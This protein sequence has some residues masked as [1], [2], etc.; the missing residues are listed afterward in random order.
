MSWSYLTNGSGAVSEEDMPFNNNVDL[1]DISQIQ[2]KK[3]ISQVYDTES[4]SE[5]NS[6][7][8]EEMNKIKQHIQNFGSV[9]ACLHGNSSDTY[10]N[11]CYNNKTG[12]KYCND[13]S[14]HKID[15]AVSIIGWDDNYSIEN[16][17]KDSRPN[18][19]GAWI[20]K[21][22]W[23]EKVEVDLYKLKE[24]LFYNQKDEF[25]KAGINS[26]EEISN[27]MIEKQGYTID[28]D[29]AYIK[30][31]DNGI[32]YVSYEDVNIST[33]ITGIS[34]AKDEIE[35]DYIYQYDELFPLN[36]IKVN[37]TNKF[38]LC[39]K[40]N[41]KTEG[42]EYLTQVGIEAFNRYTCKVYVNPNGTELSKEKLQVVQLKEGESETF[43][44]GYH[45]LEFA[46]P[47]KING[48]SYAVVIEVET[49][50]NE[51]YVLLESKI[52][53]TFWDNTTVE[54]GKCFFAQENDLNKCK[55]LD[56]GKISELYPQI[57]NGDS[58][59]KAF[60]VKQFF[61]E[62]LENIE[63]I[64]PPNKV[65]YIE[66]ENFDK[67]G[68]VVRANYNSKTKP[69][70]VLDNS[71][72]SILDGTNLRAGQETIKIIYED[73][74]TNQKI[75]VE[76]NSVIKLK[77]VTP[78]N[79]VNYAE[80]ENFDKT[81]L[82]VEATYKNG[83]TKIISDYEIKDGSNLMKDQTFVTISIDGQLVKQPITVKENKLMNIRIAKEPNKKNYI[84]GQNFDKTGMVVLGIFYDE[85]TKEIT[86]YIIENGEKLVKNQ[87]F[88]KIKYQ[89]KEAIQQIEVKEKSISRISI[90][91]KPLKLTYEQN[92]E[93]LDLSGGSIIVKYN[94]NSEEEILLTSEQIHATGF[95]NKKT[96]KQII[97]IKYQEEITTFEIEIAGKPEKQIPKNSDFSETICKINN[98]KYYI[99]SD[100]NTKE[101]AIM[102]ITLNNI[103]R[104]KENDKVEYYYYLSSNK[105]EKDIN[106]WSRITEEQLLT[107]S[108]EFKVNTKDIQNF[109]EIYASSNLYIYVKEVAIKGGNQTV[110]I[111][112]AMEM[113][114]TDS[115][116]LYLDNNKITDDN[117]DNQDKTV[118]R[119]P[120][121]QTG[122][123]NILISV[124]IITAVGSV[125]FIKYKKISRYIK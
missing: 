21:N 120:I 78:P 84:V 89:D 62:S 85:T 70:V 88:V 119:K 42:T 36:L 114:P 64:T 4:F 39:N 56:L 97:T 99:F 92:K 81:G 20:V 52:E 12:A 53:G 116:E 48:S 93:E 122:L 90:K 31:G 105:K 59:I 63:V 69:Y 82:N 22:S 103:K 109:E 13:S 111:S 28:G 108:M 34:K 60:T 49:D 72:Y 7:N 76:K 18:E 98:I 41:K 110:I 124:I 94:D 51:G 32:I 25:I 104:N 30:Y 83:T 44:T 112:D 46:K 1:I 10:G 79:K 29:K 68:M 115:I 35:Y 47:I 106:G 117:K 77:I 102:E 66:G 26:P 107:N 23:G 67:T 43:G 95:N 101:Y 5:Y 38:M 8:S 50:E 75:N 71:D 80:G 65:N 33:G 54:N 27:E 9:S 61:D 15:H 91:K 118:A 55:W 16:F 6:K 2:N 121:P 14:R 57:T 125:F 17:S 96:G 40:F 45:T 86:D 11:N 37:D 3:V 113:S 24:T 100:K 74:S 58:S 87:T 73:K 19:N 123:I